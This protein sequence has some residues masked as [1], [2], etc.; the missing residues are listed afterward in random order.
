V[1]GVGRP[2]G[3]CRFTAFDVASGRAVRQIAY[4]PDPV[5]HAPAIPGGFSDNGVS[6]ILMLD[7][8]RMLV[9]ERGYSMGV[10]MSLRLYAID[11][12]PASDTLAFDRLR[13]GD[14]QPAA[15]RL[16]ADFAQLGLSRLDN[17]EGMCWGPRLPNGHR[18][19]VVVSDDNF[20]ARQI[21]QFAAFEYL[22][23]T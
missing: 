13:P 5:Q 16:V 8:D 10:G 1:P 6:E 20:S 12:R 11:T 23:P 18:T 4:L 9:L 17:T 3:P 7:A 21:T 14:Y 15:K 22:E 2:G 19:L